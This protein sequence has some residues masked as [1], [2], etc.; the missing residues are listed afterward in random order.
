MLR[1]ER[2]VGI[3]R[4]V[5]RAWAGGDSRSAVDRWRARTAPV[6]KKQPEVRLFGFVQLDLCTAV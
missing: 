6:K 1:R 5:G 4:M 3:A 2:G